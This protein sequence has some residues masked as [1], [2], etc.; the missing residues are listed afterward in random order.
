MRLS[1]H[2]RWWPVWRQSPRSPSR[3]RAGRP[4][5]Q[6][7]SAGPGAGCAEKADAGLDKAEGVLAAVA[8]NVA[9][10]DDLTRPCVVDKEAPSMCIASGLASDGNP[11]ADSVRTSPWPGVA[12]RS[13]DHPRPMAEPA[14]AYP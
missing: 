6:G 11:P 2:R 13:I 14:P 7:L 8:A 10:A 5:E 9:A 1:I 4:V 3:T 12:F